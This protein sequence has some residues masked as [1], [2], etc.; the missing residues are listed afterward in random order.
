M[1]TKQL[2]VIFKNNNYQYSQIKLFVKIY[3]NSKSSTNDYKYEG[4]A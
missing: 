2:N 3:T 4:H 1:L